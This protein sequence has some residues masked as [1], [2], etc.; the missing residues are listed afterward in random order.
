MKLLKLTTL[1]LVLAL[2]AIPSLVRACDSCGCEFCSPDTLNLGVYPAGS[3][4]TE[5]WTSHLFAEL[6]E[7]Y[8]DF[9]T[10][11][12]VPDGVLTDQYE[13]SSQTQFILGYQFNSTL[14]I[15]VSLPYIYRTYRIEDDAGQ[16]VNGQVNGIGDLRIVVNYIPVH[17]EAADWDYSWRVSGGVKLPTGDASLLDL[18][19]P[20]YAGNSP[21]AS[22]NS[23]VGGHDVA[24]GSGS[25][26]GIL[27]TGV[28]ARYER[29]FFNADVDYSIR[30]TG[31]AGYRYSNE[32]GWSA[33]PGLYLWRD[34]THSLG[35]QFRASGEYKAADTVQGQ[36]TD[37]TFVSTV[38]LGPNLIFKWSDVL[39]AHLQVE[40][41]IIQRYDPGFQALP[42]FR[43]KA[44]VE[45][46]L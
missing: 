19:S 10:L 21:L 37:D 6:A 39:S 15:Q 40:V 2:T 3:N 8:T 17:A 41:P 9:G 42:T 33:G 27:G 36:L 1:T 43:M 26:D 11:R 18:E 24:L 28:D 44:G 20:N 13:Y 29:A 38:E 25:Y 32:I 12:N 4:P 16:L 45:F 14:N 5:Y 35:L 23:S 30:G 46:S 7:Q 22:D 34:A 31:R